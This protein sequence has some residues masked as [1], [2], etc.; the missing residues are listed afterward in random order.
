MKPSIDSTG[1]GPQ[2]SLKINYKGDELWRVDWLNGSQW[3]LSQ[4]HET[5]DFDLR[6]DDKNGRELV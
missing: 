2:T 3:L 1:Q 4:E 6:D 5:H